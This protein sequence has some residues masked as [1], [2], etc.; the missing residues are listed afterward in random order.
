MGYGHSELEWRE[1]LSLLRLVGYD[2]VLSIEHE[3]AL[4]SVDEGL[5]RAVSFLRGVMPSE[6]ALKEAW[7]T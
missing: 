1:W 5:R 6:P 4:L 7:W 3:D 2:G